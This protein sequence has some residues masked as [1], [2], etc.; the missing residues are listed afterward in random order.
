MP[1]IGI[2]LSGLLVA[3]I[4][5][6][7]HVWL[8]NQVL[9]A[10][11]AALKSAGY[12][13]IPNPLVDP[14]LTSL[15]A[16]LSGA[17]FFTLTI[18]AGITLVAIGLTYYWTVSL[19]KIDD[20]SAVQSNATAIPDK[21]RFKKIRR[22]P[23]I[24]SIGAF[25]VLYLLIYLNMVGIC[26][27]ESLYLIIIPLVVV[28]LTY[29]WAA[30]S[31]SKTHLRQI[32]ISLTPIV[33][34]TLIW[35]SQWDQDLFIRI[36]DHLL[37]ESRVGRMINDFY[38][39]YTLYPAEVFKPLSQK[40]L[41]T[42]RFINFN[43]T[44]QTAEIEALLRNQ[45]YLV[46]PNTHTAD[47]SIRA[48]GLK[49]ILTTKGASPTPIDIRKF[50][51]SSTHI[52]ADLSQKN[53]TKA[54]FRVLVFYALIFGF[55]ITLYAIFYGLSYW[56][57]TF[58]TRPLN[59]S[60]ITALLCFLIGLTLLMP[61]W[62][63]KTETEQLND[64]N[65]ALISKR[66]QIRVATLRNIYN[67]KLEMADLYNYKKSMKSR[68]I[69]ERYWLARALSVSKDSNTYKDLFIL[70][71]DSQPIVQCQALYALGNRNRSSAITPIYNFLKT[72]DHWY[73]QWYGYKALRRLGWVQSKQKFF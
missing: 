4:V 15:N 30:K 58:F 43:D 19:K 45:D 41:R 42:C 10:N 33:M 24:P 6:T 39:R 55:P 57:L 73:I 27:V 71:N 21:I 35:A 54:F 29:R 67:Q 56:L 34:L 28:P 66:F 47:L 50:L 72:S 53:D 59:A 64:P 36:R 37:L 62:N 40:M 23:Y 63:S 32:F 8:S 12:F 5:A 52:L 1:F 49:L 69:S 61:L 26:V 70:L 25:M 18:G 13:I 48:K 38:Y 22:S 68:H 44:N 65:A 60:I 11:L 14:P 9:A 46:V 7:L 31:C 16:A 17:I 20:P 3:Q 51:T 2:L